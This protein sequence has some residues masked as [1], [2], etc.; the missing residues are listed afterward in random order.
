MTTKKRF[1]NKYA[2]QLRERDHN[3]PHVHLY[4]CGFDVIIDLETLNSRGEW[5][6]D[7]KN[8]VM[9]WVMKNREQLIKDWKLWHK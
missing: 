8:E 3:P 1:K 9:E 7:A 2:L 5:P 4:G 6:D